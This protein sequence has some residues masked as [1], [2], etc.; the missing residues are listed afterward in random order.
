MNE[1]NPARA[2]AR[3]APGRLF[4]NGHF[5]TGPGYAASVLWAQGGR[6][7]ALGGPELLAAAPPEL[8][9]TDLG[10]GWALPGFNDS[11]LHLLD[12]GRGLASVDPARPISPRAAPPLCARTRCRPGRPCTATAGTRTC[13]PGR[14]R[15]P[16][17][18]TWTPPCRTTRCCSTASAGTSC[19]ATPPRCAPRASQAKR[20]TRPAVASTAA[21]AASPTACC[22]ITPSPLCG[23]CCQPKRPPPA[24]AA[25]AR[26]WPMRPPTA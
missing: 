12:V 8:P 3:T 2:A 20:P 17:A 22:G 23:R 13:L 18:P 4:Y 11:H 9:R 24:P 1:S 5:Y 25:G 6:I 26:R 16:P 15:C 19:C 21:P 10:G 7:R 14:T